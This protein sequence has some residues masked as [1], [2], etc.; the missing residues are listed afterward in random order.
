MIN[1]IIQLLTLIIPDGI[2]S[3]VGLSIFLVGVGGE[4]LVSHWN[5]WSALQVLGIVTYSFSMI[6]RKK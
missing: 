4:Y 5:V 3:K 1:K 6:W 2:L